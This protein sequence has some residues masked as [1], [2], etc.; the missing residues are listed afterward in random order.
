MME[1]IW[2]RGLQGFEGF[3]GFDY[4]N[5]SKSRVQR[6]GYLIRQDMGIALIVIQA[7]T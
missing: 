7:S 2:T 6:V 3:E 4:L 5:V 1:T